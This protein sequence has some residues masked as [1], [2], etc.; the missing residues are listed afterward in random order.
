MFQLLDELGAEL[1]ELR[2][3]KIESDTHGRG[4]VTSYGAH[5]GDL[6]M[7]ILRLKEV[8]V[9]HI[10]IQSYFFG[11]KIV[12]MCWFVKSPPPYTFNFV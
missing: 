9:T 4:S 12:D 3:M 5:Y 7:E 11:Y 1:H 10:G 6:E 8:R 2:R